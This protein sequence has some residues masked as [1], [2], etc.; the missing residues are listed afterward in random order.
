MGR[1]RSKR[2]GK[3]RQ[4]EEDPGRS[5]STIEQSSE[6]S[7][8]VHG[9]RLKHF[10]KVL[11]YLLPKVQPHYAKLPQI[12]KRKT[13]LGCDAQYP[14]STLPSSARVLGDA[15][16]YLSNL[17]RALRKEGQLLS[18]MRCISPLVDTSYSQQSKYEPFTIVDFGGGS[19]HLGIPLALL[20]PQSR[21]IVVDFNERSIQ[22]MHEKS[23]K[24]IQQLQKECS[25][26]ERSQF[27]ATKA[28]SKI[29]ME[30]QENPLFRSCA[31]HSPDATVGILANLFSFQG[32]VEK[33]HA[34]FDMALALHLCGEA[35][36]IAIR[37]AIAVN[38]VA[39]VLAP[40]CV[41]KLSQKAFNPDVF[42]ATGKNDSAV[43][44]PQS[45]LFCQLVGSDGDDAQQATDPKR[46]QDDWDALAKAADYSNEEECG[47]SLN[48]TRRTAK[49]LLET[50][51]R[52]FL[53]EQKFNG[54]YRTALTKMDPLD[55][56]PKNDIL[57]AWRQDFYGKEVEEMFSV[58]NIDCQSD[59]EVAQAHLLGSQ[60][61]GSTARNDWTNEEEEEIKT[62]IAEFLEK[63]KD[64]EDYM[65]RIYL[66]PTKMGARKRK[67]IHF[68]AGTMNLAHWS[69]G[70]KD[71][72]KTVAVARR[73]Q[74][75]R[76]EQS[77]HYNESKGS[78]N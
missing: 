43:S 45:Y 74:R 64:M 50:D 14:F 3:L 23:K 25:A 69:H 20:L 44:Y 47:T 9:V 67:L 37:K 13:D 76:P 60:T 73:G 33:F 27:A 62:M 42:N 40:C 35:T 8:G 31:V 51:R 63:T 26:D 1:L 57:I 16:G 2:K 77:L 39:M 65:D 24:V 32:P 36:D 78:E 19:G 28:A 46:Q 61:N 70:D 12:Q 18:M 15:P 34:P 58:P 72:L 7:L 71:S 4:Q 55:V 54:G 68:V 21:I 10:E 49:A 38:A 17:K 52:L 6:F 59:F 5:Q 66:F 56:T 41:G 22:L 11:A 29:P 53:E 75:K 48:A 30:M